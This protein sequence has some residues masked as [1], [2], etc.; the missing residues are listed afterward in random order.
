VTGNF[1][2]LGYL[3]VVTSPAVAG[4]IIIDG[5]VHDDW[6]VWVPLMPGQH[7]VHFGDVPGYATPADQQVTVVAG[8]SVTVTGA[9]T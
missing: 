7:T 4:T 8:T 3:H 2:Q 1:V 6:G 5:V 9:Y